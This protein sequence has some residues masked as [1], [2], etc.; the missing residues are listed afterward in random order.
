MTAEGQRTQDGRGGRARRTKSHTY[1]R[2]KSGRK[3]GKYQH[4]GTSDRAE[5]TASRKDGKCQHDDTS[6]RAESTASRKDGNPKVRK[7]HQISK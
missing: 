1:Q 6:Y 2:N 5:S 4:D 3:D 7:C